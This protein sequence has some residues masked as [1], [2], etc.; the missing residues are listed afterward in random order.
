MQMHVILLFTL[1]HEAQH[2]TVTE[3]KENGGIFTGSNKIA[4]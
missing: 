4:A 1:S 2:K 3:Y